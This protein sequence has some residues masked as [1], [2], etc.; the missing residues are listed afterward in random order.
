MC[1]SEPEKIVKLVIGLDEHYNFMNFADPAM[2][3][4]L[5][6]DL[7]ERCLLVFTLSDQ[8][9]NAG[10]SFQRRPIEIDR[11]YGV[12][13]SSFVW[14]PYGIDGEDSP[15]SRFKIIYECAR[16]G[17]YTYSLLMMDS[18][19]QLINLDPVIENGTGHIESSK[20]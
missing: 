18:H 16:M 13:F 20:A 15:R 1:E 2:P 8:L 17:E 19:G 14:V 5:K 10:W 11:D 4:R 3:T 6:L 7:T 12:N 9:I